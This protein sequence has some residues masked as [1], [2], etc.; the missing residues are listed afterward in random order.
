MRVVAPIEGATCP[1]TQDLATFRRDGCEKAVAGLL[2]LLEV[3]SER[4]RQGA[5]SFFHEADKSQGLYE[6][7]KDPLRLYF[8]FSQDC[9][10]LVLCS[11]IVRK[12]SR[13]TL[14]R[15]KSRALRIKDAFEAAKYAHKVKYR[16]K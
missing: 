2:K 16:V 12:V 15:D 3:I 5:S 4:G 14:S 6:F 1:F 8:F 10:S 9:G 13:A 11:H 7:R